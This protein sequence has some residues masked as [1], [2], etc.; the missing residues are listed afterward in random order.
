MNVMDIAI[1]TGI[2]AEYP[3]SG[4]K[5]LGKGLELSSLYLSFIRETII[6][7][8][9]NGQDLPEAFQPYYESFS[10]TLVGLKIGSAITIALSEFIS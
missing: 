8:T 1:Y 7:F 4:L 9:N 3:Q 5:G 10:A 6:I 2:L